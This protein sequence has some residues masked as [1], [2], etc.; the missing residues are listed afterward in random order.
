MISMTRDIRIDYH[1]LIRDHD[2]IERLARDLEAV[3][4]SG[5]V[6]IGRAQDLLT[7][8]AKTVAAHFR[9]E[10]NFIYPGLADITNTTGAGDIVGAFEELKADW[11]QYVAVWQREGALRNW[12]RFGAE[13]RV[14]LQTLRDR[15]L[16]EVR[17]LYLVAVREGLISLHPVPAEVEERR[18]SG[19]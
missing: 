3:V 14:A 9:R 1:S 10:E 19:S 6:R 8:L 7:A 12:Q 4:D 13:T 15:A 17:S 11:E 16:Q 18:R 2:E 5:V